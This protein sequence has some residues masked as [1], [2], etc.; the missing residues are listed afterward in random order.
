MACYT[1]TLLFGSMVACMVFAGLLL[2]VTHHHVGTLLL[3]HGMLPGSS[4]SIRLV[5]STVISPEN[6]GGAARDLSGCLAA[7]HNFLGADAPST[8]IISAQ[9]LTS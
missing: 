1:S 8:I 9:L 5:A 4:Q 6:P 3:H 2:I 7:S